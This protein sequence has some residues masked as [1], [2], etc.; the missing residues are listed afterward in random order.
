MDD[1]MIGLN[2]YEVATLP[3]KNWQHYPL[4]GIMLYTLYNNEY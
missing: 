4:I 3:A 2:H 1:Q